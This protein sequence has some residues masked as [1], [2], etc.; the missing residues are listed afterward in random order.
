MV[1]AGSGSAVVEVAVPQM[2]IVVAVAAAVATV[3]DTAVVQLAV[4]APAALMTH[5]IMVDFVWTPPIWIAVPRVF[6]TKI[7]LPFAALLLLGCPAV[8]QRALGTSCP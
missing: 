8:R 1:T 6:V 5:E 7:P 2:V 4:D 3:G